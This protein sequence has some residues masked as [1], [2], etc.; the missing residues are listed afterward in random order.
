M[1]TINFDS[2]NSIKEL[3]YSN[4][5]FAAPEEVAKYALNTVLLH[6]GEDAFVH[7]SYE[8]QHQEMHYSLVVNG[9]GSTSGFYT[10]NI[11]DLL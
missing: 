1:G 9:S 6:E 10:E 2:D 8:P 5:K 11:D 7:M 4:D 3:F